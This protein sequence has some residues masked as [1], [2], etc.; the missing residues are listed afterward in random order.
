MG[1]GVPVYDP[2]WHNY[3]PLTY[4]ADVG[5]LLQ[6]RGEARVVVIG[7][8]LGGLIAMLMAALNPAALAGVVLNDVGPEIDPAG[9]ARIAG[10]VGKLP[11][12]QTWQDA[13]AQARLVNGAS[14]PDYTDEDWMRFARAA[15]RDDGHG[16][17]VLDMDPKIGDAMREAPAG[18][19]PDLWPLYGMLAKVPVLAIRGETSDILSA[20]TFA[21]MLER[22]PDLRTLRV[23]A[24]GHAPT[25]DEPVCRA[26][27]HAFLESIG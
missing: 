20:A 25:L 15:Y 14:L 8:S 2:Q 12:V 1:A 5:E 7:T 3:Q 16:N 26:A 22:K 27:I 11:P 13:A 6:Q 10:Y 4:V 21:T 19:A 24:R 9:L 17:P 23:P 18:A